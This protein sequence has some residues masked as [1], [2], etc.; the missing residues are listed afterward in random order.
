M[1][2]QDVDIDPPAR[3]GPPI[4]EE[5]LNWPPVGDPSNDNQPFLDEASQ[6]VRTESTGDKPSNGQAEPKS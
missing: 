5:D 4:I 3:Q 2:L 6:I 1:P